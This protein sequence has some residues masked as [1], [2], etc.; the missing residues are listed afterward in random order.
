MLD[1]M[2][3]SVAIAA[4]RNKFGADLVHLIGGFDDL[5]GVA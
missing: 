5:C 3:H 4:L 2:T 1:S